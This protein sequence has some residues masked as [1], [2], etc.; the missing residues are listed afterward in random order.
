MRRAFSEQGVRLAQSTQ[1]GP[2]IPVGI[3]LYRADVGPTS[4]PT[5]CLSHFRRGGEPERFL[6]KAADHLAQSDTIIWAESGSNCH[7]ITV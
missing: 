6:V 5:R 1:V 7:K 4:G 2:C 3:Q